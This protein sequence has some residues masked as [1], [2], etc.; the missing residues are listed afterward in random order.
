MTRR[1]VAFS[2]GAAIM[3]QL[4][5]LV[6]MVAKA[7]LPLWMGTEIRVRTVPVDPRS[8]FRGNYAR[9][10]YEFETL[11]GDALNDAEGLRAGEVV[12]VTLGQGED[13]EFELADVSL[14]PPSGGIFLRGRLVGNSPPLH[15][16]Y[17]IEAFFAPKE[18]ALELESDLRDGGTAI[19]MVTDGGRAA[20]RDVIPGPAAE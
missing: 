12:Y 7:A 13:G 1:Q 14:E 16:R 8:M 19:L 3:L 4:L 6:G 11:P 15:V 10:R 18:R 20:L 17:G 5:L 2:L 9:L